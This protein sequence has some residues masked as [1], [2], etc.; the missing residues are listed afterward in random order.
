[1]LLAYQG[2]EQGVATFY[3]LPGISCKVASSLM[4][5]ILWSL[6]GSLTSRWLR[7]HHW[8]FRDALARKPG[9]KSCS[10][11]RPDHRR[12]QSPLADRTERASGRSQPIS[13]TT[14]KQNPTPMLRPTPMLMRRCPLQDCGLL[15]VPSTKTRWLLAK[16]FSSS[17][18]SVSLAPPARPNPILQAARQVVRGLPL[19]GSVRG[20]SRSIPRLKCR[21][22]S[23]AFTFSCR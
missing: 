11:N 12:C 9:P 3:D 5:G 19:S 13:R 6:V 16:A 4:E 10:E 8:T 21:L 15:E 17:S 7:L 22:G 14:P 18:T 2:F 1:L 23:G 20:S